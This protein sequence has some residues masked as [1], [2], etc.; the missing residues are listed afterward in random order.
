MRSRPSRRVDQEGVVVEGP[1]GGPGGGRRAGVGRPENVASAGASEQQTAAP[2]APLG[3]VGVPGRTPPPSPDADAVPAKAARA[4]KEPA[5]AANKA[6]PAE[7]PWPRRPRGSGKRL[8]PGRPCRRRR[9]GRRRPRPR[10]WR[11]Q[12]AAAAKAGAKAAAPRK[13]AGGGAD[14]LRRTKPGGRAAGPSKP[15]TRPGKCRAGSGPIPPVG[16]RLSPP[17]P[18]KRLRS[19]RRRTA[20]RRSPERRSWTGAR[21]SARGCPGIP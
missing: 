21:Y 2:P 14:R 18:I 11:G 1:Q 20:L 3:P 10:R 8:R 19:S 4:K 16:D 17:R 12:G 13:A 9:A 5:G 15:G 6:A 7:A